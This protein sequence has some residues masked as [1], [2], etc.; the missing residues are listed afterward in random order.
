MALFA[1]STL[2]EH[3]EFPLSTPLNCLA[4]DLITTDGKK[5]YLI[6]SG[7][8]VQEAE[9][10]GEGTLIVPGPVEASQ[11][12]SSVVFFRSHPV[13]G[14]NV[15][16]T[17]VSENATTGAVTLKYSSGN[18]VEY[19]SWEDVGSVANSLDATPDLAEKILALKAFR[20]SPDGANK[21]TQV[22]ASVSVNGLA[23][24]PIVYTEPQ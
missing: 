10:T 22:G 20:A 18:Q 13:P 4:G 2:G 7:S 9:A 17:G 16:M 3:R 19:A 24:T 8:V 6:R 11:A 21:T 15:S 14:Q 23:D 5:V 1:Q 12:I